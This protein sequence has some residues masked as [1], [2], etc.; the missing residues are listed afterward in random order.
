MV[1]S[2]PCVGPASEAGFCFRIQVKKG[3]D[4]K[5]PICWAPWLSQP[6]TWVQVH[7]AL[8]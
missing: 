8:Q 1:L 6:Q 5:K 2:R 4:D 7:T 3:K